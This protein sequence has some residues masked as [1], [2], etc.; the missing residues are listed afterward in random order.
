MIPF[1]QSIWSRQIYRERKEMNG[2]QQ[3]G[4]EN[5]SDQNGHRVSFWGDEKF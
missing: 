5:E 4:G 2:C 1:I 3:M